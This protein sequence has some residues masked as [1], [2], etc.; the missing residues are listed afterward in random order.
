MDYPAPR[1]LITFSL[2]R[3]LALILL[4]VGG[5]STA[6]PPPGPAPPPT[7]PQKAQE[8]AASDPAGPFKVGGDV[9]APVLVTRVAPEYPDEARKGGIRGRVL[10]QAVISESG[11]V[12]SLELMKSD[13]PLLT[14]AALDAIRQW[15]Y[16]PATKDGKPVRVFLTV[17]TTFNVR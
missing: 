3:C 7:A 2:V 13:H 1:R 10:F 4:V 14:K 9:L 6:N 12:E 15:R 16:R 17:T 5:C 8:P 11:A